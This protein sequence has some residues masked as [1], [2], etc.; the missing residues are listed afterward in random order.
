[1][2]TILGICMLILGALGIFSSILLAFLWKVP[3]LL[4]DLSGRKAKRQIKRL[5]DINVGTGGID[6]IDTKDLYEMLNNSGNLAWKSSREVENLEEED[7]TGDEDVE[8]NKEVEKNQEQESEELDSE[9]E[10]VKGVAKEIIIIEEKSSILFGG[11][12]NEE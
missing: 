6:G 7:V 9:K 1:M 5:R 3:D 10:N 12:E 11:N 8:E 4:D 2:L